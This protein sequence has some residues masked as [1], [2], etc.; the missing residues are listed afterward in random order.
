MESRFVEVNSG[1]RRGHTSQGYSGN[2][3]ASRGEISPDAKRLR[4]L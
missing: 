3:R 4:S 2:G 1:I